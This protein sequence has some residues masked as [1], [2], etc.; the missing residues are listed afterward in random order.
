MNVKK[1][2]IP[3]LCAALLCAALTGC[4]GKKTDAGPTAAPTETA[5]PEETAAPEETTAPEEDT[6]PSEQDIAEAQA[7]AEAEAKAITDKLMAVRETYDPETVI[8]TVNGREVTWGMYYYF[9]S[10]ALEEMAYYTGSL[11]GDFNEILTGETT[12]GDYFKDSSR[13]QCVY[14]I[15]AQTKAAELG[16]GLTEEQEASVQEYWDSVVE[17]YGGQEAL[18]QALRESCLDKDTF[19]TFLRSNDML[20]NIMEQTYGLEGERLTDEQIRAWA[21]DGG[22]AR[23]KHILYYFYDENGQPLDEAAVAA[24]KVKADE[25]LAELKA[26]EDP[27]ALEARFDEIM[28]ADTGDPGLEDFPE[29]YTFPPNSMYEEFEEAAFALEEYGLSEIVE[30]Q[31][32]YHIILR[33]PLL[34]E[35]HTLD[36]NSN[37]GEYMTLRES[38]ANDLFSRELAGWIKDAEVVWTEGFEDLD[39]NKLFAEEK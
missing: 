23:T 13:S 37:T 17:H 35:G 22:Y 30:S 3:A 29:G 12:M 38:A 26:I 27:E 4:A 2:L 25:T 10:G 20:S 33:L 36:R 15:V 9:L 21:A 16:A 24:L 28:A 18:E 19:L 14:Y 39:L 1:I 32:G 11:P 31:S 6:Q 8:C 7:Q 5:V 34:A